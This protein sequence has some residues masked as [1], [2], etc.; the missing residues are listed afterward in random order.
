[1]AKI[2]NITDDTYEIRYAGRSLGIAPPD[3]VLDI[4]DDIAKDLEFPESIWSVV[5]APAKK[6]AKESA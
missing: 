6:T 5:A 1:M 4:P 3:G 2:R